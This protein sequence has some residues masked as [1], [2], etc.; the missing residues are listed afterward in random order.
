MLADHVNDWTAI[1]STVEM[2]KRS[3]DQAVLSERYEEA[4]ELK[5]KLKEADEGLDR[6]LLPILFD[7]Q[8]IYTDNV[9]VFRTMGQRLPDSG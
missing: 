1:A 8:D 4:E 9:Y 5:R 7:L 3:L 6:E 2:A